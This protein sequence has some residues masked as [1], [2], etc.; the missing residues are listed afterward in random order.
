MLGDVYVFNASGEA[1]PVI[2][3]GIMGASQTA[4]MY[5]HSRKYL[6]SVP[7]RDVTM[8]WRTTFEGGVCLVDDRRRGT[9][10]YAGELDLDIKLYVVPAEQLLG[11]NISA[12]A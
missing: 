1:I 7:H 5:P 12:D 6:L 4:S 9:V 3:H 11:S 10:K 2:G 8:K